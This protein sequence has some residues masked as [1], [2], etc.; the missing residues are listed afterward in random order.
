[1]ISSEN[2]FSL[3]R[4]MLLASEISVGAPAPRPGNEEQQEDETIE[5]RRVTTI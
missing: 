1:V 5:D 3:I 4:I 2:W